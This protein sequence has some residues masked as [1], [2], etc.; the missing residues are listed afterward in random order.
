VKRRAVGIFLLLFALWPLLQFG[1]TQH[2]GVSPWKL[3]GWAMY[4]VPGA[5][6][7]VRVVAITD[8]GLRRLS[9]RSYTSQEQEIVDTFRQHR[10]A[11]GRLAS[12]EPLA[13]GMLELHPE[14]DGVVVAVLSLEIARDSGWLERSLAYTTHWRDGRDDSVP[15]SEEALERVFGP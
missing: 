3:F 13:A 14:F 8:E 7:T 6:K 1:L 10:Q 4:S 11:L 15:L 2:Y 12:P 9:L 5:M